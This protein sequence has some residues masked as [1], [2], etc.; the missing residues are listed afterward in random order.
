[1]RRTEPI[2]SAFQR[3]LL[4]LVDTSRTHAWAV[5]FAGV[6]FAVGAGVYAS[7]HLGVSTDT[8]QMSLQ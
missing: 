5:L 3:L 8:D 7:R 6:L 2:G 1:M 4:W